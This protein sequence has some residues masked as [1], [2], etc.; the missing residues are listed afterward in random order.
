MNPEKYTNEE[1]LYIS[2]Q[3]KSISK[4][5]IEKEMQELI[6][7]NKDAYKQSSR[8]RIG[9]NIVDYFT[10]TQRLETRGK[11]NI[12]FF[13]FL[14]NIDYFKEKKFIRNMIHY[15]DTVKNKNKTKNDFIVKKE[16]FNICIS[17]INIRRPIM[18]MEIY[19]KY[20][21]NTILDFCA[22][23]GGALVGASALGIKKYIGIEINQQLKTPYNNLISFL[24]K[25]S[26]TEIEMYFDSK[27]GWVSLAKMDKIEWR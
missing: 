4:E 19:C 12:N 27:Y 7:I 14:E 23:W 5:E 17:A 10:F 16:I 25:N 24:K 21:P 18:C 20:K 3:I 1:K 26:S 22:G 6:K 8:Y 11:Y 9:N 13:D 15:Y 2:R